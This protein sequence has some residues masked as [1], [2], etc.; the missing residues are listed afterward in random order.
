MSFPAEDRA[1]SR[2]L[3]RS[4]AGMCRGPLERGAALYE[5]N[6]DS[7]DYDSPGFAIS[8][9]A[10]FLKQLSGL[11]EARIRVVHDGGLRAAV[12]WADEI[13]TSQY[14]RLQHDRPS[15]L[16]GPLL[17]ELLQSLQGH[18]LPS[19]LRLLDTSFFA[20]STTLLKRNYPD[21]PMKPG[22]A[23][24]KLG[25]V[26]DAESCI[27]VCV[28]HRIGQDCDTGWVDDLVPP[29]TPIEGLTFLFDRGFRKY[30]FFQRLIDAKAQF[31]TRATAQITYEVV[32]QRRLDRRHP[33]IISDEVVV[34]G[35]ER[36]RMNSSVRRIELNRF[37][38]KHRRRPPERLI[39]LASDLNTPAWELCEL[40]RRRWD[41][42]TFFRWFKH[43]IGCV[44]PMGYTAE[45]AAHAFYAAIAVYLL[46]MLVNQRMARPTNSRL[47]GA[48][49]TTTF[50]IIRARLDS[51]PTPEMLEAFGFL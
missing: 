48:G 41:I 19:A 20:L 28:R 37:T 27:P 10:I 35:T 4:I 16:W 44:K 23:G 2:T 30:Q 40:Y 14:L 5:V 24:A 17:A 11:R 50:Q 36:N 13:S 49:L 15:E 12:G 22:T 38:G 29:G 3:M 32:K 8:F 42:E 7:Q 9:M 39:F 51:E 21:K 6:A 47:A 25:M 1:T 31:V 43:T 18:Q 45:A 33:E 46:V 26:L 34:L